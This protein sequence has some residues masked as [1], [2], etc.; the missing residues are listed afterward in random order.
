MNDTL[1]RW[2]KSRPAIWLLVI[3]TAVLIYVVT[4]GGVD[5]VDDVTSEGTGGAADEVATEDGTGNGTRADE[6]QER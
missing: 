4:D 5:V 6:Q 2:L 1:K 3:L